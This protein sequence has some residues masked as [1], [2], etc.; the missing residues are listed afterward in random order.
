VYISNDT[1]LADSLDGEATEALK[2]RALLL[3]S[4][5]EFI[6]ILGDII[7]EARL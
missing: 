4:T 1:L 7:S 5:H 3:T 2:P 6:S